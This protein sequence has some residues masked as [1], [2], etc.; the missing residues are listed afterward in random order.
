MSFSSSSVLDLLTPAIQ[1]R[2]FFSIASRR[3]TAELAS[4]SLALS[5]LAL[6]LGLCFSRTPP[7]RVEVVEDTKIPNAATLTI[8]KED[9]TLANMLRSCVSISRSAVT[10]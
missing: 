4:P 2:R 6:P 7:L 5:R 3:T 10:C 8:N 9:H 1:L